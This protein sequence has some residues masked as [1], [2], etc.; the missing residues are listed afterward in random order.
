M[1]SCLLHSAIVCH[2]SHLKADGEQQKFESRPEVG[3]GRNCHIRTELGLKS[4]PKVF[5]I[6][7]LLLL[8]TSA[9]PSPALQHSCNQHRTHLLVN[10]VCTERVCE[11]GAGKLRQKWKITAS[12]KK[13]SQIG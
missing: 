2:T 12:L 11:N 10:I 3:V 1:L 13:P 9:W 7:F 8:T 6:L 4:G 5:K